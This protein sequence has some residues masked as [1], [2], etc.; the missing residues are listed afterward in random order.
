MPHVSSKPTPFEL[1]QIAV[2]LCQMRKG[3]R[4]G[5]YPQPGQHFEEAKALLE[6]AQVDL[7]TNGKKFAAQATFTLFGKAGSPEAYCALRKPIPFKILLQK[8]DP[9]KLATGEPGQSSAR[10]QAKKKR[11]WV[12]SI[13]TEHG[14][15][16]A[17]RRWFPPVI[18]GRII[19]NKTMRP[20]EWKKLCRA[21][22]N[23]IARRARARVKRQSTKI[24][25]AL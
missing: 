2:A 12:G 9:A 7:E 18:A 1:T 19:R 3:E 15:E 23:A 13:T 20:G 16:V 5:I 6:E 21:Q 14:L 4:P 8:C 11:T 22:Q 24:I 17:V 10:V 25:Q